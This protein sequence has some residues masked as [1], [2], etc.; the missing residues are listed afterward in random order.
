[1]LP[2]PQPQ[3]EWL[4]RLLGNWTFEADCDMG[5]DQPPMKSAGSESVRAFGGLWVICDGKCTM[6]DGTPGTT[7]MALGFDPA[8]GRFVGTFIGSMM[9]N[10]W[11]YDG[12]L[13]EKRNV[14]TLN[15]TGPDMAAEGKYANYKDVIELKSAN[16]RV[17]TSHMQR[18]DGSWHQF[19]TATYRRSG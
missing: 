3:H 17:L 5:P 7:Q 16:E 4:A 14:L 11:V 12:E 10:L 8:R 9:T 2:T 13:D 15:T 18:E 19:L 6:P 1:M